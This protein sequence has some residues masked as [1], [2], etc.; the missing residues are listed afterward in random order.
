MLFNN[1]RSYT[2]NKTSI[3]QKKS[4]YSPLQHLTKHRK[5]IQ[6]KTFFVQPFNL[7][8][9]FEVQHI[10]HLIRCELHVPVS[11]RIFWV[12]PST[13]LKNASHVFLYG[14]QSYA[15]RD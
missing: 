12:Y 4:F 10:A 5:G 9:T 14:Q 7:L 1:I 13:D 15:L 6:V 3:L 8:N 2:G 11:E